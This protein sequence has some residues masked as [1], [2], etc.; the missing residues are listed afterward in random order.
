MPFPLNNELIVFPPCANWSRWLDRGKQFLR[1][2]AQK[3]LY[4]HR[5]VMKQKLNVSFQ[6][7]CVTC[8]NIRYKNINNYWKK[9]Y[10]KVKYWQRKK[11]WQMLGGNRHPWNWLSYKAYNCPHRDFA[12]NAK[13]RG[14]TLGTRAYIKESTC[15]W[16]SRF[17]WAGAARNR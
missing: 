14:G 9:A 11:N 15:S 16:K 5:M 17:A 10:F 4:G 12:Q 1:L 6:S 13:S 3:I 2:R 7:I 8:K